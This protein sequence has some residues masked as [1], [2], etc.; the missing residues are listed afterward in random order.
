MIKTIFF[1]F[2]GVLTTDKTGSFTTC[3]NIQKFIPSVPLEQ[4]TQCYRK[5]RHKLILGQIRHAQ[6]WDDFCSCIGQKLDIKILETAF[7]N[8]PENTAMM[9]LCKKLKKHYKLGIITDNNK[10][11]FDLLKEEMSLTHIFDYLILSADVG[12]MK[13]SD[14][15]FQKALELAKCK[16]EECV[17]I[18]NDPANLTIPKTL[19]IKTIFHDHEK[20]DIEVLKKELEKLGVTS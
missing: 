12:A 11:R 17:F 6:M 3:K 7:K 9:D 8:T 19:G 5:E 18:D 16:P 13:D 20:N 4:I 2:D 10:E 14:L 15:I 1:D